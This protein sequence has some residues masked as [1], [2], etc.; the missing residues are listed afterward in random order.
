MKQFLKTQ[1]RRMLADPGTHLMKVSIWQ[2]NKSK[3][4][5]SIPCDQDVSVTV[6]SQEAGDKLIKFICECTGTVFF[7]FVIPMK[8]S[9][10]C[11]L[12]ERRCAVEWDVKTTFTFSEWIK[13]WES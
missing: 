2:D 11:R 6:T 1:L 3:F 10:F 5:K 8:L 7:L 12:G 13:L 4:Y 9:L